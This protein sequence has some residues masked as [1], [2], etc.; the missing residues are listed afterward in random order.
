[1]VVVNGVT[2][3]PYT[4]DTATGVVVATPPGD[5]LVGA[6]V[7]GVVEKVLTMSAKLVPC[8]SR[9]FMITSGCPAKP[10]GRYS[11]LIAEASGFTN[12]TIVW[13]PGVVP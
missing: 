5:C 8:F 1:M 13:I 11:T 2:P 6:D 12:E 10:L 4:N 7:G 9:S 3:S